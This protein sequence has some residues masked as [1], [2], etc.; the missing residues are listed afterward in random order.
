MLYQS[1]KRAKE[2]KKICAN[3]LM[4]KSVFYKR[5]LCINNIETDIKIIKIKDVEPSLDLNINFNVHECCLLIE[6]TSRIKITNLITNIEVVG[7]NYK[8]IVLM[9]KTYSASSLITI[10]WSKY[11]VKNIWI[12]KEGW[13]NQLNIKLNSIVSTKVDV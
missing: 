2:I 8:G 1:D 3:S 12:L 7:T 6:H 11:D 13:I 9:K 4:R 10:D 5:N